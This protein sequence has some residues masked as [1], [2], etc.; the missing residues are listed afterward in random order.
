[1]KAELAAAYSKVASWTRTP[2]FMGEGILLEMKR[3]GKPLSMRM[4]KNF[5]SSMRGD[6]G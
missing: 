5:L 3:G 6:P 1:V 4:V 2:P